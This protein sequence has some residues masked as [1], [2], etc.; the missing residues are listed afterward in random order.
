[1]R[2]TSDPKINTVTVR[3]NDEDVAKLGEN[4]SD[5]IRKLINNEKVLQNNTVLQNKLTVLQ[6]END[7][8]REQIKDLQQALQFASAETGFVNIPDEPNEALKDIEGSCRCW[9]VSVDDFLNEVQD[10]INNTETPYGNGK[11]IYGDWYLCEAITHKKV[12][13]EYKALTDL[14]YEKNVNEVAAC[15]QAMLKGKKEIYNQIQSAQT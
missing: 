2:T 9:N 10:T 4:K 1:M 12:M 15:I 7:D 6:K 3:L 14:C 8:L 11:L 13:D 5:T